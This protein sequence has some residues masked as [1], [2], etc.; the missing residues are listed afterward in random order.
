VVNEDTDGDKAALKREIKRLNEELAAAARRAHLAAGSGGLEG[1]AGGTPAR[2]AAAADTMLAATSPSFGQEA[3]QAD[4][5]QQVAVWNAHLKHVCWV[6]A[7]HPIQATPATCPPPP[8]LAPQGLARRQALM[9]ALR[10]EDAAV[11]E[12]KRLEAELEGM[13]GLVKVGL[14]A[15]CLDWLGGRAGGSALGYR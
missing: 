6:A 3:R 5:W 9:G 4:V 12:A 13:R 11:K 2:L 10:R 7:L 14:E 8:L 15:G 1:A